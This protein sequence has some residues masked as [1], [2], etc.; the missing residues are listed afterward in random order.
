MVPSCPN[1][2]YIYLFIFY[3]L[4]FFIWT[5]GRSRGVTFRKFYLMCMSVSFYS[6]VRTDCGFDP[7]KGL[8]Q[9]V[10]YAFADDRVWWSWG[11]CSI[12]RTLT[13]VTN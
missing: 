7:R 1:L 11:D 8:R 2:I 5:R 13:S 12:G 10:K 6:C 3:F 9:V 4:L